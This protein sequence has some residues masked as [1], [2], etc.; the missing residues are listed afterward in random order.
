[1][2]DPE[3]NFWEKTKISWRSEVIAE[4]VLILEKA[5]FP[6]DNHSRNKLHKTPEKHIWILDLMGTLCRKNNMTHIAGQESRC[7]L[8]HLEC[9]VGS[10]FSFS[11]FHSQVL[12]FAVTKPGHGRSMYACAR[13][14]SDRIWGNL[15]GRHR[16]KWIFFLTHV[17]Q[18]VTWSLRGSQTINLVIFAFEYLV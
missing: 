5:Y 17:Y 4:S 12:W 7:I 10:F 9:F 18:G 11:K 2:E 13:W 15:Q 1:M 14:Q 6:P 3:I 16:W 8:N